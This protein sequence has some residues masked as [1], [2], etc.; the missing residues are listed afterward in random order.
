MRDFVLVDVINNIIPETDKAFL[1]LILEF[2]WNGLTAEVVIQVSDE[3]GGMLQ[4]D[5]EVLQIR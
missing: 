4:A 1:Y 2:T 3:R 5:E